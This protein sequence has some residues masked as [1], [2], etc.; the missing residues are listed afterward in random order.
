MPTAKILIIT[1]GYPNKW[2]PHSGIYVKRSVE[3]ITQLGEC[4]FEILTPGDSRKGFIRVWTKYLRLVIKILKASLRNEFDIIH[5]HSIF[6]AG[7][8]AII[9]KILKAEKANINGPWRGDAR[10]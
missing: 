2:S 9:P 8:L 6:P 3:A 4:E 1:N 10:H 7:L 5:A